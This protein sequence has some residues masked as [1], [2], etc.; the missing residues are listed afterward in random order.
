MTEVR[1]GARTSAE[2]RLFQTEKQ[3]FN[4]LVI[5]SRRAISRS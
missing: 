2:L 3:L 5:I 1:L 4:T